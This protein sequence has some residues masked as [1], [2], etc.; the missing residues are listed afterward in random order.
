MN[1]RQWGIVFYPEL[2]I[3]CHGCEAACKVWRSVETG[4]KWRRVDNIWHGDYPNVTCSSASVSCLHCVD[5]ACISICP[6]QAI[7]K[8]PADGIVFV[9]SSKCTGCRACEDACTFGVPQFGIDGTMQK[10]D[11]CAPDDSHQAAAFLKA[12]PCV[13]TCPT[14]ALELKILTAAQKLKAEDSMK[15]ILGSQV[16]F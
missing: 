13:I 7:S 6:S 8:R 9:D 14:N 4:I 2:C 16:K 10:C 1:D 11:L 12:P 5:P 3:Q 15:N